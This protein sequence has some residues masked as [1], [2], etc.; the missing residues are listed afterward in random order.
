MQIHP[1][2]LGLARGLY[3]SGLP[4]P[5]IPELVERASR[6]LMADKLLQNETKRVTD[7]IG[8]KIERIV[9]VIDRQEGA[10][11]N[12][13]GAGFTFDSLFTKADLGITS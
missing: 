3:Q 11:E 2:A 10:R 7:E 12:I 8:A 1:N 6:G 5:G 4:V 9:A 13:E